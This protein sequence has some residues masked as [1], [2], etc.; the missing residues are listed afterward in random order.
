MLKI[1]HTNSAHVNLQTVSPQTL[2]GNFML[3]KKFEATGLSPESHMVLL[4][5]HISF[6]GNGIISLGNYTC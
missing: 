3:D 4:A 2:L 1:I 6:S 5:Q